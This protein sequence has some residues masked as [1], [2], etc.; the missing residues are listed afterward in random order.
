MHAVTETSSSLFLFLALEPTHPLAPPKLPE[1]SCLSGGRS[2]KIFIIT[3]YPSELK[4]QQIETVHVTSQSQGQR[5]INPFGK[6]NCKY[7]RSTI[8][9]SLALIFQ[10]CFFQAIKNEQLC[11]FSWRMLQTLCWKVLLNSEI[12]K[13]S[14]NSGLWES[15]CPLFG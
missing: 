15:C 4:S 2:G 1:H 11:L 3:D 12:L 5:G 10:L 14:E 7:Q 6:L 9:K 8:K 13:I